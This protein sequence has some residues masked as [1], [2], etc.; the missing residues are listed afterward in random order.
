MANVYKDELEFEADVV[1]ALQ[2][3]GRFSEVIKNP[4]EKDLIENR[5]KILFQNNNERSRLNGVPLT[6]SEMDQILEK[7][8]NKSV[9]DLNTNFINAV[10]ISIKRDNKAD[11]LN[12]GKEIALTIYNRKE[13]AA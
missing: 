10:T 12:Y 1:N 5:K 9:L 2:R 3:Y 6:D 13:I 7:I 11:E 8:T 4:T